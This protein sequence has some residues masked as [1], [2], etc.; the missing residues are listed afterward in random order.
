MGHVMCLVKLTGNSQ[1]SDF[2]IIILGKEHVDCLNVSM[3]D[4][5]GMQVLNTKTHFDE[6]LPDSLF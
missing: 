1:V 3:K 2:N 4:P 6:K 5:I